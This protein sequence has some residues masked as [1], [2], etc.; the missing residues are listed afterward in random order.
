[1]PW[2]VLVVR[3]P[4]EPARHRV[5]AW[6]ELRKAGAV[7]L[8]AG[9]WALPDLPVLAPAVE[10]VGGLVARC[11][12]GEMLRLRATGLDEA[13]ESAMT[14]MFTKARD[15][16]WHEFA[17]DAQRYLAEIAKEHRTEKYTLAELEEEEQ[18]LDRL[19]RWYRDIRARDLLGST[20]RDE[21]DTLL[22][23]CVG[24][25]DAFAEA[26]YDRMGQT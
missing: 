23:E 2:L 19:R 22:K 17:T 7:P 5:A 11:E 25:F 21:A 9:T 10:R 1:L 4:S 14:T 18:S 20:G 13:D 26:V 8:A 16:E 3:L 15:D 12:G 24:A 6:R